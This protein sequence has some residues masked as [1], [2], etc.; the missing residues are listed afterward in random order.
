MWHK[1]ISVAAAISFFTDR[2]VRMDYLATNRSCMETHWLS[3]R[4]RPVGASCG[5]EDWLFRILR[6]NTFCYMAESSS[7]FFFPCFHGG[8]PYDCEGLL[9]RR[10]IEP[11]GLIKQPG[12][13]L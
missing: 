7:C 8:R 5:R 13:A 12:R 6:N 10:G 2:A 3:K 9:P 1:N 4:S 11:G